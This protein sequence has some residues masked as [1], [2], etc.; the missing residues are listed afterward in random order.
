[1]VKLAVLAFLMSLSCLT[2]QENTKQKFSHQIGASLSMISGY[3]LSYQYIISDKYRVKVT[4]FYASENNSIHMADELTTSF[5]IEGQ[6]TLF[7]T[8]VTRLY[9]LFGIG[10]NRDI[11]QYTSQNY[12][13]KRSTYTG[14]GG[15]GIMIMASERISFNVDV[16]LLYS[17][18]ERKYYTISGNDP[19]PVSP[20][21]RSEVSFGVGGGIGLGFQL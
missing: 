7:L 1:M 20:A 14:G 6:K 3:G 15:F 11:N 19:P 8:E 18:F 9:A 21:Y 17:Y 13:G 2:A 16:G 10:I 4:G 5:G 12:I